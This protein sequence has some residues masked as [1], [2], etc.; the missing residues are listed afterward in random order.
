MDTTTT[1]GILQA[2]GGRGGKGKDPAF[3]LWPDRPGERAPPLDRD[4]IGLFDDDAADYQGPVQTSK[5]QRRNV[6]AALLNRTFRNW[7]QDQ[8]E[9]GDIHLKR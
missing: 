4:P 9:A 5:R 8:R 3:T 6:R 2:K 7:T 1:E